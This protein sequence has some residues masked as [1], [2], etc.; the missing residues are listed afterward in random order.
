MKTLLALEALALFVLSI[1][2]FS[3]LEYAWWWYPLLFFVPDLG[4]AGYLAGPRVGAVVYNFVHHH[5]L[6]VGLYVL[7]SL[8]GLAPLQLAGLVLFGHSNLDRLLGYGLK[9]TDAFQHTHL[10]TIGQG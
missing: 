8:M 7:G 2:L 4:M 9:H 10:G 3:R 1:Y 6:S 5:A